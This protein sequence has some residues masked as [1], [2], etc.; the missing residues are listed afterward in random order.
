MFRRD[1]VAIVLGKD[2]AQAIH[3]MIHK[4]A[5]NELNAEYHRRVNADDANVLFGEFAFNWRL[6]DIASYSRVYSLRTGGARIVGRTAP[7]HVAI[8]PQH[9]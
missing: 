6:L 2:I 5:L 7:R 9:Y 8:L 4:Q 1:P 3:K